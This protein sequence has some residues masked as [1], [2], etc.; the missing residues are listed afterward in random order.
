MLNVIL[1][2]IYVA[3]AQEA[4]FLKRS[5]VKE[6]K[7]RRSKIRRLPIWYNLPNKRR[8]VKAENQ[9]GWR[10]RVIKQP[11]GGLIRLHDNR[12]CLASFPPVTSRTDGFKNE[13][14][15]CPIN[16]KEGWRTSN[17]AHFY[18][19]VITNSVADRPNPHEIRSDVP[20]P[21]SIGPSHGN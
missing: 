17:V 21:L 11:A 20:V 2:D 7:F 15:D 12:L 9:T 10:T 3:K 18:S 16:S 13:L 14:G 4:S 1:A 8:A 19:A 5:T 6:E